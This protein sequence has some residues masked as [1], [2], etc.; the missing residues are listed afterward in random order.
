MIYG[1]S[2]AI[3]R[4]SVGLNDLPGVF[5]VCSFFEHLGGGTVLVR[6]KAY[7]SVYVL[8]IKPFTPDLKMSLYFGENMRD[9]LRSHG[10]KAYLNVHNVLARLLQHQ[11]DIKS[12][13]T[14]KTYKEHFHGPDAQISTTMF[15]R[16][17]EHHGM[18]TAGLPHKTHMIKPFYSCV[19]FCS[20]SCRLF[21]MRRSADMVEEF[22]NTADQ[23]LTF[24]RKQP[25]RSFPTSPVLAQTLSTER[26]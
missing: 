16:P 1:R 26:E 22:K 2:R 14:P 17:I 25:G 13:A 21:V 19:H 20:A 8:F 24:I 12:R 11:N 18:A 7:G 15:R 5:D 23:C 9:L 6:R 3:D 4:R 10:I